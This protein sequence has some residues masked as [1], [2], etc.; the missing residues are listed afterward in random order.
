MKKLIGASIMAIVMLMNTAIA[1]DY[2]SGFYIGG[3]VGATSFEDDDAYD[4]LDLD[5]NDTSATIA[6]GY[7]L[8][9]TAA[10]ELRVSNLGEYSVTGLSTVE[11]S[12]DAVTVH[13]VGAWPVGSRNG[14]WEIVGQIGA[15]VIDLDTDCCGS[16]DGGVVS[17]GGGLRFYATP[18]LTV[19][20]YLDVYVYED[21]SLS[22]SADQSVFTTQ[23]GAHY[24]F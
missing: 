18:Q 3:T 1:S 24:R 20:A 8:V 5:D 16:D 2:G 7:Q 6:F 19:G 23:L 17:L 13:A 21:D 11:F 14:G 10:I 4:G 15:G 9:P 22:S 12:L